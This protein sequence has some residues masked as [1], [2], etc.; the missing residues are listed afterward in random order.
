MAIRQGDWKLVRYDGNADTNTGKAPPVSSV[1][2]YDLAKDIHEDKDLA[3]EQPEKVK[4]LQAL[5]DEWNRSNIKP[6]WGP[7]TRTTTARSPA[8]RRRRPPSKG[9]LVPFAAA[10]APSSGPRSGGIE[11]CHASTAFVRRVTTLVSL[12]A[13]SWV[14][15]GSRLRS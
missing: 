3:A 8:R 4:Q 1:K 10:L 15:P 12:A 7:I 11:R 13:R 9:Y 6:L 14:S 5:W 2:L